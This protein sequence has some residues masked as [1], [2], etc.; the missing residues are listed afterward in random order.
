ML[1][2]GWVEVGKVRRQA[3]RL[4]GFPPVRLARSRKQIRKPKPKVIVASRGPLFQVRQL[5]AR[6]GIDA[7]GGFDERSEQNRLQFGVRAEFGDSRPDGIDPL[8]V[9]GLKV[10]RLLAEGLRDVARPAR[11]K[12]QLVDDRLGPVGPQV[13][14]GLDVAGC[15]G[16]GIGVV[17]VRDD[18]EALSLEPM[19]DTRRA[20]EQVEDPARVLIP[21]SSTKTVGWP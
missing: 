5:H 13:A 19:P 14:V 3:R 1:V 9:L 15:Q 2:V 6:G 17:V 16:V 21:V 11:Q 8:A 20:G 18:V 7:V 12:V 4:G 10:T